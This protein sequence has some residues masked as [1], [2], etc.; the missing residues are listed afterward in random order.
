ML[1]KIAACLQDIREKTPLVQAITNYVSINDCANILLCFGASPAMCEAKNEVE[2]FAPLISSLYINFGTL[3]EEQKDA[4]ILAVRKVTELHKPI[5]LDPIACGVVSRRARLAEELSTSGNI[6]IIKGN[7]GE[8]KALA[9]YEAQAR[10]ADSIDDG[11]DGIEACKIVAQKYHAVVASTG[12][13]DIITD[14]EKTCLIDNGTPMLTHITAA[15]CMTGA[16]TA[17][18]AGA[19][20]DYFTAACAAVMAM[21]LSGELVVNTNPGVLPGTFRVKLF[22]AIYSM[23]TEDILKGGKIK[24]L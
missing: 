14:G 21:G 8:I 13:T 7:M 17:A 3:N 16:L 6:T 15:G 10:G 23:T 24:C 22:D 12:K 20:D 11:K 19:C 5:V 1:N 2:E 18:A 9:G 4:S